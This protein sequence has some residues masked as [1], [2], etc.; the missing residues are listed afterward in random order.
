MPSAYLT[1]IPGELAE[2]ALPVRGVAR[3]PYVVIIIGGRYSL[4]THDHQALR[5]NG[6]LHLHLSVL[7]PKS[8][9]QEDRNLHLSLHRSS[10]RI[11]TIMSLKDELFQKL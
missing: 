10:C 7:P 3:A 8:A 2:L 11:T 1:G 9:A 6:L 5:S 4:R